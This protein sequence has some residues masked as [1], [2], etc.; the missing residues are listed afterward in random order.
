MHHFI[1]FLGNALHSLKCPS[2][3]RRSVREIHWRVR[4]LT[5]VGNGD[6]LRQRGATWFSLRAHPS[7]GESTLRGWIPL[8]LSVCLPV[9]LSVGLW[10]W[11]FRCQRRNGQD[12]MYITLCVWVRL[13]YF[14]LSLSLDNLTLLQHEKLN[15]WFLPF[16]WNK[17]VIHV[18]NLLTLLKGYYELKIIMG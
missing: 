10:S 4:L 1:V 12:Y 13:L 9:C 7:W 14:M 8:F 3:P 5:V 18:Y 11:Q 16:Y 17:L 15:S 6:K 2:A